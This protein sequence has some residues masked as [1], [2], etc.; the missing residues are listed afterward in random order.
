[1]KMHVT[2]SHVVVDIVLVLCPTCK[3]TG[4]D[5]GWYSV[6]VDCPKCEGARVVARKLDK[7]N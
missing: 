6:N 4:F 7:E 1:M 2:G 5:P 3:G